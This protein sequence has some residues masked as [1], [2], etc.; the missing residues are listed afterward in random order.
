[1]IPRAW[2]REPGPAYATVSVIIALATCPSIFVHKIV[3][4]VS[5]SK[6]YRRIFL[7]ISILLVVGCTL[8]LATTHR[9]CEN[10]RYLID[11]NFEGGNFYSCSIENDGSATLTIRPEDAPPINDS[12]W[13]AF[14]IYP[15]SY[16]EITVRLKFVDGYARYWPKLSTDGVNW[17]PMDESRAGRSNDGKSMT[18]RLRVSEDV[19]WVAAQELLTTSYYDEWIRELAARDDVST[20]VLGYSVQERPIHVAETV[21]KLEG[22]VLIGRQ[23]PPEVTGA[24]AMRP[25]VD[26]VFGDTPLATRFRDRYSVIVIPLVNPDGVVLGHWRHNVNGVDL[27]RDWGPFTQPETQ[28]AARLLSALD[29]AGLKIRLM[30]DFHSTKSSLFYTQLQDDGALP[31]LF[32]TKWLSRARERLPDF[33][34]KHDARAATD[35]PNTKN[36]FFK[37]YGIPAITYE[38]GDESDRDQIAAAS[39]VFAEEMMRLMLE[40]PADLP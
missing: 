34:F 30:L 9:S 28:S 15:K 35:Q 26:T 7:I 25:F 8:P 21:R 18:I 33:K 13:Y 20:R 36:Y 1:M 23:H 14:R 16:G 29:E 39:P 37:R 2:A 27:N 3:T 17:R 11:A 6:M 32:A 24:I 4:V 19:V 22:I 31:E 38:L 12:P 40:Q 10:D 5:S